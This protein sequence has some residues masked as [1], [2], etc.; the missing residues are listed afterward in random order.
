MQAD[1]LL[2]RRLRAL[3]LLL[4]YPDDAVQRHAEALGEVLARIEAPRAGDLRDL[5]RQLRDADLL[6]LQ[7][8]YVDTFDRGRSTSLNLFEHVHGDSRDRGQAM[9][10]LLRQYGEHGL[11]LQS[12][13]LPDYLPAYLEYCSLLDATAAVDALREIVPLLASLA[14]ALER[15]ESPWTAA[16]TALCA[17]AGEPDWRGVLESARAAAEPAAAREPAPEDWSAAALD[18]AWAEQPVDF[19]GACQPQA[20][21][22]GEQAVHFVASRPAATGPRPPQAGA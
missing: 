7:A 5:L 9:V 1:P 20:P 10:D 2:P 4:D 16:V 12:R 17:L 15:R 8:D 21:R 13:Q 19:L 14:A 3:A 6:D 11:Q 22:G 18:A